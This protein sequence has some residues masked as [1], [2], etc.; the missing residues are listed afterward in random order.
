MRERFQLA[1]ELP[2]PG[3]AKTALS[4]TPVD[5][6]EAGH[7]LVV[8]PGSPLAIVHVARAVE[9][10]IKRALLTCDKKNVASA[11]V[12]EKNGGVLESEGFSQEPGKVVRRYWI[13]LSEDPRRSSPDPQ[14]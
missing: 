13:D 5:A 9:R 10:G 1:R 12:I 2:S 7:R 6:L 11:K 14:P 4:T 3:G 8:A